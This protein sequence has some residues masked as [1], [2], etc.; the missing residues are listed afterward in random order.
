ME[1]TVKAVCQFN[2][3]AGLSNRPFDEKEFGKEVMSKV[4]YGTKIKIDNDPTNPLYDIVS[5][6]PTLDDKAKADTYTFAA[7][8]FHGNHRFE[9]FIKNS[10]P[11]QL[12]LYGA[13]YKDTYGKDPESDEDFATGYVVSQ[14]P[15][16]ST[17]QKRAIDTEAVMDKRREEGM[18]DWKIKNQITNQ[19]KKERIQ[20]NN[21]GR[22]YTI[23]NVPLS[24]R[25][26]SYTEPSVYGDYQVS[27]ATKLSE[28]QM[29]DI[30]GKKGGKFGERPYKP[31]E[32]NGKKLI[33]VL[34]E[35]LEVRD[36]DGNP[37]IIK[38]ND[39]IVNTNK[40]TVSLEKPVGTGKAKIRTTTPA[41]K[42]GALND[43]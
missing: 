20:L 29:E 38:D 33:K 23:E 32:T 25:N 35:G 26:N 31:I 43:L 3:K 42:V 39:I 13:I 2:D 37:V 5:E 4:K 12:Q 30:F 41:H 24:V 9:K 6:I 17:K 7:E 11:E 34:P 8:K 16:V 28:G 19:Q 36:A 22:V 40:R 18:A 14:L 1:N 15:I 10:K 27:D 21:S